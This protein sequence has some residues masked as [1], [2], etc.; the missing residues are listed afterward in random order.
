MEYS[1]KAGNVNLV[2][3]LSS[4]SCPA[5]PTLVLNAAGQSGNTEMIDWALSKWAA[6]S[7]TP[8]EQVLNGAVAGGHIDLI[9]VL[10]SKGM[11][12][13]KSV[14]HAGK[15][16]SIEVL[17]WVAGM[18]E[19]YRKLILSESVALDAITGGYLKV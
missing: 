17:K 4:N 19:D 15:S 14:S 12:L 9:E 13:G 16:G 11:Q 3:W 5:I 7:Y 8:H 1:T 10:K 18:G 6:A 2:K